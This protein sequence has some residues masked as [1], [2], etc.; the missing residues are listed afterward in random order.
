[1]NKTPFLTHALLGD[2]SHGFFTRQGGVSTGEYESLNCS[3]RSDDK[4]E[5]IA[6]NMVRIAQALDVAENTF[7]RVRQVHGIKVTTVTALQLH[8]F[9][10]EIE[11]ADAMVTAE[12][13]ITLGIVT[14]DC[15]PVLFLGRKKDQN[16]MVI[17]AAHAGWR[18]AAA[19]ILEETVK[20]MQMLGC[21]ISTLKAVVGPCIRKKSYQVREDMR[22]EALSADPSLAHFFTEADEAGV[23]YFDLPHY[24]RA[25]L[26]GVHVSQV[27][28]T[29]EDTCADPERFFSHRRRVLEKRP[30]LGLQMSAITCR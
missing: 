8:P 10:Y 30:A 27:D 3:L 16:Q 14:A 13:G 9:P 12:S 1:M 21:D 28:V 17:G 22:T 5:N 20:S 4:P 6:S 7:A 25:R 29:G 18:G 15:A 19:G 2:T 26:E 23:Y 11:E 24:C